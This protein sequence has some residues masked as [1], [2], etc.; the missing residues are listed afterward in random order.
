MNK[1]P[2]TLAAA[3][4]IAALVL[5]GGIVRFGTPPAFVSRLEHQQ[6]MQQAELRQ[7]FEQAVVMLHA[8]QYDH[9]ITALHRVLELAPRMP[10][11]HV[12]MG[13][14]LIGL[15]QPQA[16]GGFFQA[17]ID[18][19]PRQANAYYGLALVAE[20]QQDY[21]SALGAMRTYL[22]FSA[23][24]DEAHRTRARS[25]LWEWE[26]KLGRHAAAAPA[27]SPQRR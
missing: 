26:E 1:P 16:A 17:A 23:A 24:E 6:Q 27:T 8:R 14:A 20:A 22:H 5:V 9:A 21:E 3:V 15:Q 25:A 11:A 10:E 7:R 18:L 13:Y 2:T 12:N 4:L 19:N